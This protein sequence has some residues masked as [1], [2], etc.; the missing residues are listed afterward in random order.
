MSLVVT[1]PSC[2]TVFTMVR[3]QLDA[4][5]GRVRCG[6]CMEVFDAQ[7]QLTQLM[8]LDSEHMAECAPIEISSPLLQSDKSDIH[9]SFVQ[10][11]RQNQFW[12][13]PLML[14]LLTLA[15]LVLLSLL[16][17]QVARH[18][19]ERLIQWSPSLAPA[20]QQI[21]HLWPCHL[22]A[23]RIV[24]GWL[25]ESSSF[26]KDGNNALRLTAT[27][28]NISPT[29]LFIPQLELHLLDNNDALLVRHVIAPDAANDAATLPSGAERAYSW[30]ITPQSNA[31]IRLNIKDVVGYR[32][33]LFYL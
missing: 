2:G 26:Q 5:D 6:H 12:S 23:R 1:C 29:T 14:V 8:E 31:S 13:K 15:T 17:L 3:E 32:L 22:S 33:V 11:S 4:S 24:E 18:E 7:A 30:L 25:I 21:C 28:K 9:L 27:L 20:L 10:Q 19:R 16:T